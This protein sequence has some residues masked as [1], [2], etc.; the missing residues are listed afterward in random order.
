MQLSELYWLFIHDFLYIIWYS[1]YLPL[2]VCIKLK[3]KLSILN[4]EGRNG[5]ALIQFATCRRLRGQKHNVS[6]ARVTGSLRSCCAS[7]VLWY[8]FIG[9]NGILKF[10]RHASCSDLFYVWFTCNILLQWAGHLFGALVAVAIRSP[11]NWFWENSPLEGLHLI[12]NKST[13]FSHGLHPLIEMFKTHV[14][15]LQR[16]M[17]SICFRP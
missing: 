13:T 4:K 17:W 14:V 7:G 5:I 6:C 16:K 2:E 11:T 3:T 1:F 8:K 15:S 10:N 9:N 12:F